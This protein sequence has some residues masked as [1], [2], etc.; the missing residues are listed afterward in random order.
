[1]TDIEREAIELMEQIGGGFA[2]HL[3]R[4]WRRADLENQRRLKDAFG[5]LLQEYV[6]M[7]ESR[8]PAGEL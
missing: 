8:V 6:K 3:A 4:A 1:M 5:H 7:V 2:S